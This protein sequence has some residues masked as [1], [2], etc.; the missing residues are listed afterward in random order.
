MLFKWSTSKMNDLQEYLKE[1]H[2]HWGK[3]TYRGGGGAIFGII[4]PYRIRALIWMISAMMWICL[5]ISDRFLGWPQKFTCTYY[6]GICK[7]I[8]NNLIHSVSCTSYNIMYIFIILLY[9]YKFTITK[10]HLYSWWI[11]TTW[12]PVL[13]SIYLRN[14]IFVETNVV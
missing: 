14:R 3:K 2:V 1:F 5:K 12:Y 9:L 8:M 13:L 11:D 6:L 10:Y 7:S 4:L